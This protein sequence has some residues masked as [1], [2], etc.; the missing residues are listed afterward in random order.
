LH[1]TLAAH[2][3]VKSHGPQSVLRGVSLTVRPGDRIGVVGP[4]GI[5]KTTLLRIL[6]GLERP[7]SGSVT[8]APAALT[9]G[10][11]A[12]MPEHRPSETLL[13]LLARVTGVGEAEAEVDALAGRLEREPELADAYTDALDRFLLLG[14]ADIEARAGVVCADVGLR[15]PLR[16]PLGTLS[17]GE[18]ARAS[19]AALLLSRF[20]VYLLDEPTNSLD[21]AGLKRLER[22]VDDL[23]GGLVVVSHDRAFLDRTVN[24]V[25]EFEAETGAPREFAGGWSEYERARER[26]RRSEQAAFD[27]YDAERKR[28][29]G[30]LGTR[31]T[32]ARAFGP[33]ADRRGTN[34]LR[35]K[36][37]QAERRLER[38]ERV[39]KPWSPWE[40]QLSF[41]VAPRGANIAIALS[42]A[43][44]EHPGFR[45][46]PLDLE[47]RSGER[48]LV[49]GENGSGKST[50]VRALLGEEPL[51]AGRRV[52]GPGTIVGDLD[53]RREEFELDSPLAEP[54]AARVGLSV[55]E[56]RTLLA[57]FGLGA[58]EL[59][60]PARSL[61]PGEKTRASL[62][63]AAARGVNCLV[64]DEPTN[65]LDLEAI[66]QLESA[67][68][69]FA[70]AVVLVTHDRRFL[71][72]FR[73]TSAVTLEIRPG[74]D[75]ESAHVA[76]HA[77]VVPGYARTG[78]RT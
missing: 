48:L 69:R 14:G 63:A 60:R 2:D 43:V 70:G 12:Q 10:Y 76:R 71:E 67:L 59:S 54:F 4:N 77:C 18:A 57:G 26:G 55:P 78:G 74:P 34:A 40:L 6:A 24:R 50:L 61:S 33:G 35:S 28:F 41:G 45:L 29:E 46:G 9:V 22:F 37:R 73:A 38:L 3:I 36:V 64:L 52:V 65:H 68:D 31:R 25:L 72:S 49:L 58:D 13:E 56:A 39:D 62:A 20:D 53:Q 27:E 17:G 16:A 7:D 66:E 75:T 5:G 30:L 21:E 19:L 42:Q 32:Q 15:T 1:G 44:V 47:L 8:R 11:L 51:S 23:R